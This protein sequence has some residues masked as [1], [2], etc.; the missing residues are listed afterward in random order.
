MRSTMP[1][2][3][4]ALAALLG[5]TACGS[6]GAEDRTT[7]LDAVE[8][9]GAAA[10]EAKDDAEGAEADTVE[11]KL[12]GTYEF[13]DGLAVELSG[14]ERGVS[15]K[16]AFPENAPMVQFTIQLQNDSGSSIDTALTHVECQVGDE[17][18]RGEFVADADQ[19]L[20]D[21]FTSTL[22]DG[23]QATADYGCAMPEDETYLQIEVSVND[24][25]WER[26][27]IFF[28]GEVD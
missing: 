8:E 20:G 17:G 7:E 13:D 6:G 4:V 12:G 28:V 2:T 23:R 1:L 5:L 26:P 18:R 22:M 10:E 16:W 3:A 9:E 27:T 11:V 24:D 14:V 19:G 25:V 15:G 21:G